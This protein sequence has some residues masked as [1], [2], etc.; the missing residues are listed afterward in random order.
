MW[1]VSAERHAQKR[2]LNRKAVR[3]QA[4]FNLAPCIRHVDEDDPW[5][6]CDRRL[7]E[8]ERVALACGH[9]RAKLPSDPASASQRV[10]VPIRQLEAARF[11]S[12]TTISEQ[13]R[14][15]CAEGSGI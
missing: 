3:A 9:D 2:T 11:A 12:R 5:C 1:R 7:Q 8:G 15:F 10:A 14:T 6:R 4:G 13:C